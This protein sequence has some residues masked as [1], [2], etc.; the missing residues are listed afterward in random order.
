MTAGTAP[1]PSGQDAARDQLPATESECLI[2]RR[3]RQTRRQIKSVDFW[4][5]LVALAAG[6]LAYLMVAALV[7]H[8]LVP[9]GLGFFGRLFLFAILVI[10]GGAYLAVRLVPLAIHQ[11]NPVFAAQ[12]IEQSRPSLKN[13]L[14]NFLYLRR[15]RREIERDRL[16]TGIYHA[17]ERKAA[18]DLEQIPPDLAVDRAQLIRLGYVLAAILAVCCLYLVAS[19]KSPL[20]SFRRV[21][22]PWADVKAPTR[23]TIEN[24]APGDGLVFQ[25]EIV[26]VSAEV[27]GL[28]DDEPVMLYYSTADGQSVDQAIP[29]T[30]AEER[31]HHRADLPPGRFGLQQD[32][33]YYL[34]AGDCRTPRF[35]LDVQTAL[36][37]VVDRV[38][39]DYP[40]YT[41]IPDRIDQRVAD[42]KA[43]EG[44]RVTLRAT[45]N[46]EIRSCAVELD[47]DPRHTLRMTVAGPQTAEAGFTLLLDPNDPDR[48]EYGSYQ[49]RFTDTDGRDNRTPVRH[50]IEV[51][52]DLAPEIRF[53]NP[54][55]TE[56]EL[57]V[58][59]VL[60]LRV[61]AVDPDFALRRVALLAEQG[62]RRL[63]IPTL[64]E[65][66]RPE[67]PHEGPFQTT[68]RFEPAELDLEAGDKVIYWAEAEDN[69]VWEDDRPEGRRGSRNARRWPNRAETARRWITITPP[70]GRPIP[71]SRPDP[72]RQAPEEPASEQPASEQPTSQ[73]PSE[74]TQKRQDQPATEAGGKEQPDDK[75]QS[76]QQQQ[77]QGPNAGQSDEGER[78]DEG[79]QS[80][81]GQSGQGPESSGQQQTGDQGQAGETG[82]GGAEQPLQ[83]SGEGS[84][85]QDGSAGEGS[86]QGEM[87]REASGQQQASG[88][89]QRQAGQQPGTPSSGEP[90]STS[91]PIDGRTN[92]GDAF[93]QILRHLDETK[94]GD[95]VGGSPA[96][97]PGEQPPDEQPASEQR[98]AGQEAA[99][100]GD[101][102][103]PSAEQTPNGGQS[104]NAAESQPAHAPQSKTGQGADQPDAD[105]RAHGEPAGQP[106]GDPPQAAEKQPDGAGQAP[107]D[108]G[109]PPPG[110]AATSDGK[111]G[112]PQRMPDNEPGATQAPGSRS[113][114]EPGQGAQAKGPGEPIEEKPSGRGDAN[115]DARGGDPQETKGQGGAGKPSA[116]EPGSPSPQEANQQRDKQ[117]GP[118]DQSE[119]SEGE[120]AQ[121]PSISPKDSDS[122]GDTSG[123]RSGGG[124]EGGGQKSEQSGTGTAGT[125]TASEQGGSQS[126]EQGEGPT[127]P[128]AG[129]RVEADRPTG[130]SAEQGEGPGSRQ[131][132]R[133]GTKPGE[134]TSEDRQTGASSQD[135]SDSQPPTD[136]RPQGPRDPTGGAPAST[137]GAGGAPD[138]NQGNSPPGQPGTFRREDPNL[139]Y[140]RRQTNL[141]L[142]YLEDQLAEDQPDQ[143]LL[144]RLGWTRED[145][146]RFYDQWSRMR[147]EA[148]QSDSARSELDGALDS[149]GLRPRATESRRGRTETDGLDGLRE[150][151]RSDPPPER[152]D[153]YRAYR[154]GVSGRNP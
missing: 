72:L 86:G 33:E 107:P 56:F 111:Q 94:P 70:E 43:I 82:A 67:P 10:A 22:W 9:G 129:D 45:A 116:E 1:P 35:R 34:A 120:S 53:L 91:E 73:P 132:S 103:G 63:P 39:Y 60:E 128:N 57:P 106:S 17:L 143:G 50:R 41:G 150:G 20:V 4:I 52:P 15:Q 124:E 152:A 42:L 85:Q 121:S 118:G 105:G 115:P 40:D 125:H 133:P 61:R 26:H 114:P 140:A 3:I 49:L 130:T 109:K 58:D 59:G 89:G 138:R 95:D 93:E 145:L 117:L 149:L 66:Q 62:Q 77:D 51:I 83:Q 25:G 84:G 127:G 126:A 8:W 97:K 98:P 65:R 112:D 87:S 13:S 76:R 135:G 146:K 7:D 16:A 21:I 144:D 28:A 113:Q 19:P 151:L 5:G 122:Q 100:S 46:Q 81:Q 54:P 134:G 18:A 44:T 148:A 101:S 11:V 23:V 71:P 102:A 142:E 90:R 78:S 123:D 79:E 12:S 29:M 141:A 55:P 96:A 137:P 75:A 147:G 154:R 30:L 74:E 139:D 88:Q 27:D 48:A 47:C 38:E 68:Y 99:E 104:P 2:E 110:E 153:A 36:S 136:S 32:A 6:T 69:M 131:S 24:V 92:P 37:I 14:I 31:S 64:L 80:G 119:P 108:S